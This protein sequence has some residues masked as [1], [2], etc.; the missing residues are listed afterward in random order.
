MLRPLCALFQTRQRLSYSELGDTGS[1]L[2]VY[3]N[4]K[5]ESKVGEHA[6]TQQL[7]LGRM[8]TLE[9]DGWISEKLW[10]HGASVHCDWPAV[11]RRN[12]LRRKAPETA[13]CVC[14]GL[15]N[16][17][18]GQAGRLQLDSS[19][20]SSP[21]SECTE[22]M[23]WRGLAR[24]GK[25]RDVSQ[26]LGGSATDRRVILYSY[27]Y[28]TALCSFCSA[29]SQRR[30]M[31]TSGA[32]I[33]EPPLVRSSVASGGGGRSRLTHPLGK[34]LDRVRPVWQA[35]LHRRVAAFCA[36]AGRARRGT[37]GAAFVL[38]HGL[39]VLFVRLSYALYAATSTSPICTTASLAGTKGAGMR[40]MD[41]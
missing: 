13:A 31:Q 38:C 10:A 4:H 8:F 39:P 23:G 24:T 35:I 41:R 36:Y 29:D 34:I 21:G 5:P 18:R 19:H 26:A 6:T 2:D 25:G 1:G 17:R 7:C 15:H 20:A 30:L 28:M 14:T 16:T 12:V 11:P 27:A 37:Y 9:A 32:A 33:A 40:R 22:R 3:N